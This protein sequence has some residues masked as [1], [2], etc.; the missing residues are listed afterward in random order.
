M[1]NETT[2]NPGGLW[3]FHRNRFYALVFDETNKHMD[4]VTWFYEIGLPDYGPPFDEIL[5]GRMIWDW[6]MGHYV[7]SFYGSDP[8]PNHVY[9]HVTRTFNSDGMKVVEQ[10]ITAPPR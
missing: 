7:L 6:Q 9:E 1:S 5:R 8:I 10:P 4:H 2:E 3:A